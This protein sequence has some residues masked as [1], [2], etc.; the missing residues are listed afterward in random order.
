MKDDHVR[1]TTPP[2]LNKA[3]ILGLILLANSMV[4]AGPARIANV[5]NIKEGEKLYRTECSGCHQLGQDGEAPNLIGVFV[6][7]TEQWIRDWLKSPKAMIDKGDKVAL[8]LAS[9]YSFIMDTPEIPEKQLNKVLAYIKTTSSDT[10]AT[11]DALEK[12]AVNK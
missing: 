1:N 9:R 11:S 10:K 4:F 6:R 2:R 8:E 3:F 12:S 7:R 5:A